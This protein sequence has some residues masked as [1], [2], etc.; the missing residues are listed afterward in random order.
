MST[1]HSSIEHHPDLLALRAT[2][3]RAAESMAAQFTFGMTLL[4]AVYAALSPWIVG[5]D[6]TS[7]LTFNNFVVGAVVAFLA[8]GLASALDRTHGMAWTL[9]V[10]G[11]W[12]IISPW[13]LR[14]MSPTPGMIWS[15][16]VAGAVLTALGLTAAYFGRR[17]RHD[18]TTHAA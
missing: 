14:D 11:V 13:V 3:D 17:A 4:T 6:G 10:F 18:V 15:N 9:P 8:F 1:V 12:F 7:R 16:V 5:F 2:Y